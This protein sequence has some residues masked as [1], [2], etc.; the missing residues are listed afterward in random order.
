M[1]IPS[2]WLAIQHLNLGTGGIHLFTFVMCIKASVCS[3]FIRTRP[4][5]ARTGAR[6]PQPT[7]A[8]GARLQKGRE[9]PAEQSH[10]QSRPSGDSTCVGRKLKWWQRRGTEGQGRRAGPEPMHQGRGRPGA[11][12][13]PA[14]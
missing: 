9:G 6:V 4:C 10:T 2:G 5:S 13:S 8:G 3:A 7:A 1:H 14:V 11:P 12:Q